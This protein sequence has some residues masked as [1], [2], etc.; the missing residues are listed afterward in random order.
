[1][2]VIVDGLDVVCVLGGWCV[3]VCVCIVGLV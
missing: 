1:M 3:C 2:C